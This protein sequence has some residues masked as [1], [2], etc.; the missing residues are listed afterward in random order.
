MTR[1]YLLVVHVHI[2][3]LA[4]LLI[5]G[6]GGEHGVVGDAPVLQGV[7]QFQLE[8]VAVLV[9]DSDKIGAEEILHGGHLL[10]RITGL[11]YPGGGK[12]ARG[13]DR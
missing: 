9:S 4:G 10:F 5:G 7:H 3:G 11:F 2:P 6:Y 8:L 1:P 13:R 12:N